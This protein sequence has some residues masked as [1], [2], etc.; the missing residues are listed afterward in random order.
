M[1]HAAGLSDDPN[2]RQRSRIDAGRF[3]QESID[4]RIEVFVVH[5]I[6]DV[7]VRIVIEPTGHHWPKIRELVARRYGGACTHDRCIVAR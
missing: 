6:V 4:R 7:P 1:E 2:L 5:N 3:D